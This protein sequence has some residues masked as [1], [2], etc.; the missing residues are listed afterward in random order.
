MK[1]LR[2]VDLCPVCVGHTLWLLSFSALIL[3]LNPLVGQDNFGN[4]ND[5]IIFTPFGCFCISS[6]V[7]D[8]KLIS[9]HCQREVPGFIIFCRWKEIKKRCSNHTLF[10]RK[11]YGERS[12]M[13]SCVHVSRHKLAVMKLSRSLCHCICSFMGCTL[14]GVSKV[15]TQICSI[16]AAYAFYG[17]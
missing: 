8:L 10:H 3:M 4:D 12:Q 2:T 7:S 16:Y 1:I 14:H 6:Y 13:K 15:R 11:S 9:A 17:P 5:L